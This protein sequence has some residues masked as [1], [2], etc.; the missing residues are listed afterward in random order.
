M[1]NIYYCNAYKRNPVLKLISILHAFVFRE[2][3]VLLYNG[4]IEPTCH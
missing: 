2:H 1:N 4:P 3:P